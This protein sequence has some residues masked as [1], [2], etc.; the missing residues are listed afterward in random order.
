LKNR[1]TDIG[2][3]SLTLGAIMCNYS[4]LLFGVVL[5]S[6]LGC[7]GSKIASVSG[8]VKLDGEPLANAVVTFQPLGDGKMNPGVGSIGRTNE[9]GE[10]RLRLIDGGNGAVQGMH[11]VEISCP[12]DDG[13]N[14]PDEDRATKPPNKVP[15]RYHAE[16]K[17]TYEVKAGENKA[18]FDL[19]SDKAVA[20]A[21]S[22]ASRR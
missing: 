10:Y 11:R 18:D 4:R 14:S 21:R 9:K 19:T 6:A 1:P 12:V 13:Q 8:T 15:D 7:G 2:D 22:P 20:T 5:A 16:S 17:V 3:F